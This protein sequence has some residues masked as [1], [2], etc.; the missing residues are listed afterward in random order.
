MLIFIAGGTALLFRLLPTL[1]GPIRALQDTNS[2][3]YKTLNYSSQ[4]MLG[5]MCYTMAFGKLDWK[6]LLSSASSSHAVLLTLLILA[7]IFT[8][9][10][11]RVLS[12]ILLGTV[13]YYFL[14][15][16]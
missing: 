4:A 16:N 8:A 7:L 11:G 14:M 5:A 1:F 3:T 9:K 2:A 10:T 12:V 15:S 13:A 6:D